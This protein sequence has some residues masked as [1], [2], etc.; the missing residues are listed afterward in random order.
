MLLRS[1]PL[2]RTALF[3]VGGLILV[4]FLFGWFGFEPLVK[5][6]APKFI[7]DKTRHHLTI[8]AARFDPLRLSVE[9]RGLALTE[10]GGKPMLKLGRLFVDLEAV[11]L[12]KWAYVLDEVRLSEPA[13]QVELRA[14]GRLN[15]LDFVDAFSA[16]APP[17]ATAD[18]APP[19]LLIRRSVLEQGRVQ[20]ID[21]KIAG[22]FETSVEP[23]ELQLD[24]LSTL[25]EDR[26]GYSLSAKTALGATV[27]WKG[28]L[29]LNP[30]TAT[31]EVA[32]NELILA[33]LWPFFKNAL[34]MAPAEGT[35]AMSLAYRASYADRRFDLA[36]DRV[37]A[38]LDKLVLRGTQD[39]VAP[40]ALDSIR[41]S[42]GHLDLAKQEAS[43]DALTVDG[44][45]IAIELDA[46][47][48]PQVLDWLKP[49]PPA[50]PS[51][52]ASAAAPAPATAAKP[53][54]LPWRVA[55]GRV[56]V[57][58]L[59]L[60]LVDR[61]FVT[62][63]AAQVD[64]LKLQFKASAEVGAGEPQVNIEGL[65]LQLAAIAVSSG[66][67]APAWLRVASVDLSDGRVGLA[68][69]EL[70]LGSMVVGGGKM[71]AVRDAQGR[72]SLLEAL[73]RHATPPAPKSA[74]ALPASKDANPWHY[75]VGKVEAKDFQ[76][77]LREESVTPA[78]NLN[79][80]NL[81]ATAEGLSDDLKAEVPL[82]LQFRVKQ[83][84]RFEA[85][86]RVSPT[87]PSADL[88]LKLTDLALTP[89][90]PMLAKTANLVLASGKVD[91]QG[92]LRYQR[93]KASY[94][95]TFAV[96]QL[97]LNEAGT[98]DP[99]LGWKSLSSKKLTATDDR[100]RIGELALD[101][102]NSKLVI[103]K[104]RTVNVARLMK[105]QP[106]SANKPVAAATTRKAPPPYRVDVDAVRV[107]N[108]EMDFADLSLALPFGARINNLKGHLIGLSS[109]PGAAAQVEFDGIVD[110]Y[111]QARA[112]GQINLFDPTGFTDLKVVF[113]NVEMT[114]L[115]PYSATFAGR[116]IESGKLSLDLE[117]KIKQRQLAG[118]NQIVMDK[119]TL[120]ER[121]ESPTA[122]SLPLDLAIAILSD[123]DGKIDLGLPV[124][125]SLD[126]PSFSYGQII[127]KAIVNVITKVVTAPFRALGAALGISGEKLDKIA[128]DGGSAEL[129]PPEQEKLA[130]LAKL[131]AKRAGI[132]IA[133]H[134]AFDPKAD[135]D[136]IKEL[137]LRRAVAQQN[138]RTLKADE[139]P[140]PISTSQ[141]ATREALEQLYEKRLGAEALA[142]LQQRFQQANPDQAPSGGAGRLVSRLSSLFKAKPA[143][144]SADEAKRLR[145]ADLHTVMLQG[146]LDAD[147]VADARLRA[148]AV[149]R[150][151]AIRGGLVKL[152]VDAER[153]RVEEPQATEGK[154]GTIA[155][156]L[157]MVAGSAKS[158]STAASA[159]P[160][161]AP[162][163]SAALPAK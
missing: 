39:S 123:S 81:G 16:G 56:G 45:R 34:N 57:D 147:V 18:T 3:I 2:V 104:D 46:Q 150:S 25:P 75:R 127:W 92:R 112:V 87:A 19:R 95:G 136:A 52:P 67:R 157:S 120:G 74:P 109:Q 66:E 9:V 77:D 1:R 108:G 116:K 79:I 82:T 145:G 8:E 86:G 88:A 58:R 119:L 113:R 132:A 31:G 161:P 83:G 128:F 7:A 22:G 138:G 73:E 11:S 90:Q 54:T 28:E 47:G 133:V 17:A 118:E 117:Y 142:S 71:A 15:W 21:H 20:L 43:A 49:A 27:R 44:G 29:T 130:N 146:L 139:D 121:V 160:L 6:A 153:V 13:V 23:L 163:A 152:G 4:Y 64:Q 111:G 100:L 91:T 85:S 59:A 105:P 12:F 80:E 115:T 114:S 134:A 37:D 93:G 32:V 96:R 5:W 72:L 35:A 36:L 158:P 135:R 151:D 110:Q 55:I 97:Q 65:G 124:S 148:L 33:R 61:G 141:P 50:A 41:V 76:V 14:D 26:G 103:F 10:P 162:A 38:S 62:P 140:G 155:A 69:R 106:T 53:G 102:L 30:V 42:G 84:G 94:D 68:K 51:A 156:N 70:A 107:T 143:P 122:M 98:N 24:N 63:L 40:I 154:D 125:G 137:Q 60:G 78:V 129:A 89:A 48:R 131:M 99:I 159:P 101:G 149:Q 126:D 144:L